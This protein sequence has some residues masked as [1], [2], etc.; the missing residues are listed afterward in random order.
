M[1]PES[2][3]ANINA[4]GRKHV[5]VVVPKDALVKPVEHGH[6][7][8]AAFDTAYINGIPF[9][10]RNIDY[11]EPLRYSYS[12][13]VYRDILQHKTMNNATVAA[14][15]SLRTIRLSGLPDSVT[16]D[17]LFAHLSCGI[18]EKVEWA[19]GS[20]HV[21][22]TFL[23]EEMAHKFLGAHHQ[24]GLLWAQG[25][26]VAVETWPKRSAIQ[27]DHIQNRR[28]RTLQWRGKSD[29]GLV[30]NA[31]LLVTLACK[32]RKTLESINWAETDSKAVI[33]LCFTCIDDAYLFKQRIETQYG[34]LV[35][36]AFCA[37]GRDPCDRE[38]SIPPR[39]T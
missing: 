9:T 24:N 19:A 29:I 2:S 16:K 14:R 39:R 13:R 5:G 36:G 17:K 20:D 28:T 23:D 38:A 30:K 26:L 35:K 10:R 33:E 12:P 32:L 25:Q 8:M 1:T 34:H 15:M 21:L 6:S 37:F 31:R 4:S 3:L 7:P 22:V 27:I 18:I 11:F